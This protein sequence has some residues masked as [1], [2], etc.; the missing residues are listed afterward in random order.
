MLTKRLRKDKGMI[1]KTDSGL[2]IRLFNCC[3]EIELERMPFGMNVELIDSSTASGALAPSSA[4]YSIHF[5]KP[6]TV[7]GA[8]GKVNEIKSVL[9]GAIYLTKEGVVIRGC[10]E[11]PSKNNESFID[12]RDEI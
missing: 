8:S 1:V 7:K 4:Y 6:K 5:Y 10:K 9:G 2:N 12:Y 11:N 3:L